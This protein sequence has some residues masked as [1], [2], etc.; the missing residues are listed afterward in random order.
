MDCKDFEQIRRDGS[1]PI[2]EDAVAHAR[3][4]SACRQD[5]QLW[6]EIADAASGLRKE[7]DSPKL[8]PRIRQ[9]LTSEAEKPV[10]VYWW[11]GLGQK[12]MWR[13]WQAVAAMFL[14]LVLSGL[15]GWLMLRRSQPVRVD[16]ERR[17]LTER[18][19]G[20]IERAESAYLQSIEQLSRLAVPK[21][22]QP[23][24]ALLSNYRER[25]LL[26]DSAIQELRFNIE[27]NRFNAHLRRE[28]IEIYQEKQRT[29]E[30]V[31]KDE[32]HEN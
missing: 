12:P 25:L 1:T 7:W 17:L 10:R 19:L 24:S 3:A 5:W 28:L 13:Q 9:S 11:S 26:I 22:E 29:L 14:M 21:V 32:T 23:R 30:A 16:E 31:I 4:C 20:D 8:W 2:P 27:Q 15:G 6:Q 18:T